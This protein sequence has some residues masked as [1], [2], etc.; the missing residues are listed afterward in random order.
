MNNLILAVW[1]ENGSGKSTFSAALARALSE[2]FSTVL[3]AS[4]D[5]ACPSFALWGA[6]NEKKTSL[7]AVLNSAEITAGY[8]QQNIVTESAHASIGLLGYLA[9]ES[10]EQYNPIGNEAAEAFFFAVKEFAQ[11]TIVD[12]CLPQNDVFSYEAI[13]SADIID[14][15]FMCI[16]YTVSLCVAGKMGS[17]KTT[18]LNYLLSQL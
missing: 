11:V 2:H 9:G 6:D 3:L 1:G 17:G 15:L 10:I 18:F 7:G 5:V 14:F 4:A 13:N 12:C 8:L 16:K